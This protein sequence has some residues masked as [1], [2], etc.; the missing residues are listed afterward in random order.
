MVDQ[1]E[2]AASLAISTARIDLLG[3]PLDPVTTPEA[4]AAVDRVIQTGRTAQHGALN[5]AKLVHLQKDAELKSALWSCDLVT[6]DGQGIVWAAR[7]LGHRVPERVTGIDLMDALLRQADQRGYRVYLLGAR[8]DVVEEAAQ[9]IRAR[10]PRAPI[11][12][13]HHGFFAPADENDVV[14]GIASSKPDLLF[15]ALETPAKELFLAR[16]RDVLR[17]PFAMGVGGAFDVLAG[18]RKRAPIW[19]QRI[20]L[21]WLFRFAQEPRRLGARY[22]VGNAHFARLVGR[23]LLR[24][25]RRPDRR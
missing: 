22:I 24:G 20:G 23:E 3:A 18:R 6:A 25:V 13:M 16:H 2:A 10:Y 14:A 1:V 21:E 9:R 8:S 15:V 19:L 12:G 11:V 5:A 17:I 4:I 7:L